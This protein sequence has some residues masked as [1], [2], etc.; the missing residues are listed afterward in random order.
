[1]TDKVLIGKICGVHGL[2]GQVKIMS[3]SQNPQDIG[4]YPDLFD[5]NNNKISIKITSKAQG[6]N[7]DVF[8]TTI[9][10]VNDRNCAEDLKNT[11]IFIIKS[12]L[13]E[14][15]DDGFY[16]TDLIGLDVLSH[17]NEKIGKVK[18]V[19]NYG[20]GDIIEIDF[21]EASKQ[22]E[23][24]QMFSF[25]DEIFPQVELEKGF[26]KIIFPDVEEIK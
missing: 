2:K 21:N 22:K 6:K 8:I 10:G 24:I 16:Y 26:I 12:D 9:D 18:D 25:R 15:E 13:P 23:K 11:E 7:H 1:M 5:N 20:A 3:F 4:S 19:M 17:D 14:S